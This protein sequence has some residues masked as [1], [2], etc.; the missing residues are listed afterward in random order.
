VREFVIEG[1]LISLGPKYEDVY[2]RAATFV[3]K[4]LAGTQ[5]ADLPVEQPT[6][7][8]IVLN[9]QAARKL[10]LTLPPT[11]LTGADEVIE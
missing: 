10:G 7:F 6:T 4:V 2:R 9:L 8:E 11:L 5:P 3:A 1:G